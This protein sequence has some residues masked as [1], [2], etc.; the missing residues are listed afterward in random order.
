MVRTRSGYWGP[1]LAVI[2]AATAATVLDGCDR[3]TSK[4]ATTSSTAAKQLWHCG[5]HPQVVQDHPG[6]CP[7]CHMALT[8]LNGDSSVAG[9]RERRVIYWWDPMLGPSSISNHSGKSAM[10]TDMM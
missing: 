7:I 2:V 6:D 5:M 10:G 4:K 9:G 1:A 8:P 3:L